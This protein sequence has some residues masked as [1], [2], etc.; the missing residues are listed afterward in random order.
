MQILLGRVASPAV[1][2]VITFFI[3]LRSRGTSLTEQGSYI[4]RIFRLVLAFC[5]LVIALLLDRDVQELPTSCNIV[6]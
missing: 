4:S 5:F 3:N 6:L 2:S 1:S